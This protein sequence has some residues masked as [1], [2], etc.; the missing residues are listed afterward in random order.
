MLEKVFLRGTLTAL[1]GLRIGGSE[2]GLSASGLDGIVARHALLDEP[3]LP[4][5]SIRGRMRC[6]LE[7]LHG[8]AG[9]GRGD[10]IAFGP[11]E[12]PAHPIV[13]LF[14][15]A[16][17]L[18]S[19]SAGAAPRLGSA[20]AGA[21]P[22]LGAAIPSRVL[23]RDALLTT[24]ARRRLTRLRGVLPLT[25]IKA[26]VS[27]DRV[28]SAASPRTFERVPAGATFSFE[29][30]LE[31]RTGPQA[32]AT[33]TEDNAWGRDDDLRWLLIGLSLLQD[34]ALGGGG[35][36]GQGRVKVRLDAPSHRTRDDYLQ[37]RPERPLE[38]L[39]EALAALLSDLNARG[40]RE[41][42]QLAE[43]AA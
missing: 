16:S 40:E 35:S 34:D 28:T 36:R 21:A 23:V 15:A 22:R 7:R 19:A 12:D 18:G 17:R 20:S 43:G 31:V 29:I 13:Q 41:R 24:D 37:G 26:E 4:G 39:P 38:P 9:E 14:G 6:A 8:I 27:I 30:V 10:P 11:S 32:I 5:S 42:A 2:Q 33:R 3:F 25:E 1:T